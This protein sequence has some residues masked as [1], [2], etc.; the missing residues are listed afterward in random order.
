MVFGMMWLPSMS[1][2]ELAET[3]KALQLRWRDGDGT[4]R[5]KM[6]KIDAEMVRR[7]NKKYDKENPNPGPAPHREH[8]WYLPN[9]D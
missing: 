8:G 4:V 5:E 1:D 9:D 2:D 3:Y 6:Y 7:A